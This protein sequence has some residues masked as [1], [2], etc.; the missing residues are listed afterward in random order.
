[1]AEA[2]TIDFELAR[3]EHLVE[4]QRG[5]IVRVTG[6]WSTPDDGDLPHPSLVVGAAEEALR[7][8]PLPIPGQDPPR[9]DGTTTWRATYSIPK[10]L[11]DGAKIPPCRLQPA[12][13]VLVDLPELALPSAHEPLPAAPPRRPPPTPPV[14]IPESPAPLMPPGPAIPTRPSR[15]VREIY[16][17]AVRARRGLVL[18]IVGVAVV[19]SLLG[20]AIR[21]PSYKANAELLV[22][23]LP[24]GESAMSGL[25]QVQVGSDP[26]QTLETVAR[27]VESPDAARATARRLGGQWTTQLVLKHVDVTPNGGSNVLLVG[28]TADDSK[29][30]ARLANVFARAAVDLRDRRL[31]AQAAAALARANAQLAALPDKT[32]AEAQALEL[33]IAELERVRAIG[34]PTLEL[35]RGAAVPRSPDG[36]PAWAILILTALAGLV[37]AV[38]AA[39]LFDLIEPGRIDTEDEMGQIYPLPV[40]TRLPSLPRSRRTPGAPEL[41]EAL[42]TLQIQL[43]LKEGRHR[44]I[45]ITSAS[46][47]DGKTTTA[48]AFALQLA[49]DGREVIL[50]DLDL[51]K[52]DVARRFGVQAQQGL[53]A[54]VEGSVP[55]ADAVTAV[56]NAPGLSLL[57]AVRETDISM[58]EAVADQLPDIIEGAT[59]LADYVVLDTPPLGEVSD[60]LTFTGAVDDILVVCRLGQTRR[61]SLQTTRDV[62]ERIDVHPA[63]AI[64]IGGAAAAPAYRAETV[65]VSP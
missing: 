32:S 52:S 15:S 23:P 40:L 14:P 6:T 20:L 18:A 64:V 45:M 31:R 58:L 11:F 2:G 1:M 43:E 8:T 21:S 25:P 65:G 27:L 30:A 5:H 35:L 55:L 7:L 24:R 13:D 54:L 59:A 38:A 44:A 12:P 48:F 53:E 60:A 9:G 29:L 4:T 16:L 57:G 36:L 63:G 46:S 33:R 19:G 10:R 17:S 62:L 39:G 61:G 42:R 28:A 41:R 51:R 26:A 50:V 34:D 47:G 22:S 49:A 56:P 3:F 37:L